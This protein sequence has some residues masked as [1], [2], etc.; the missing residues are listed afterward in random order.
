MVQMMVIVKD[1]GID[2]D[3]TPVHE[4]PDGYDFDN[5]DVETIRSVSA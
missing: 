3:T 5:G 4:K 1:V 2:F